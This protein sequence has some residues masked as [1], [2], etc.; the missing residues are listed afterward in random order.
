MFLFDLIHALRATARAGNRIP[1]PHFE[2]RIMM[3]ATVYVTVKPSVLDPQGE[4]V[5]KAMHSLGMKCI[6]S[7]RVGKF[8]ELEIS[9]DDMEATRA[10][11]D[12]LSRDLLSNPV[13]EN[14][15]IQLDKV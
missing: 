4:A 10:K 11:L 5:R 7:A 6:D 15:R 2:L 13:I 8:I 9:G 3:K 14:Y 1:K 12:E